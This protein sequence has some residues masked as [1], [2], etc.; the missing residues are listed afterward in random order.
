MRCER[1]PSP[2]P[3][4][5]IHTSFVPFEFILDL[6]RKIRSRIDLPDSFAMA[7]ENNRPPG[8]WLQVEGC[9]N[10][11]SWISVEY[12]ADDSMLLGQGWKS[13]ARS[14]RL[15]RGQY[16]ACKYDGDATLTVKIFRAAGGRMECCAE[17]E[18]SSGSGSCDEDEDEENSLSIKVEESSSS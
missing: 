8:L 15:T 5:A 7:M 6:R 18:S 9:P 14:R 10:G 13:F 1:T 3:R 12:T 4:A 2:S 17:S 16:L 11:P